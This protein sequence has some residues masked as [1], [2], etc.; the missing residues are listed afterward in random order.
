MGNETCKWPAEATIAQP[1]EDRAR[2]VEMLQDVVG[3]D[4]VEATVQSGHDLLDVS[5]EH[6]IEH[7]ACPRRGLGIQLDPHEPFS[8]CGPQCPAH[9]AC[10]ATEVEHLPERAGQPL[11]QLRSWV[12]EVV[13]R[14]GAER[15]NAV[16][17]PSTLAVNRAPEWGFA[18]HGDP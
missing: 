13:R 15:Q 1:F 3:A 6:L 17:H 4:R 9:L 16:G 5:H 14:F 18:Y 12:L 11:D 8:P 7:G 10:T 2:V